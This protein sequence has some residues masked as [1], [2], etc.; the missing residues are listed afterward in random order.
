MIRESWGGSEELWAAMAEEALKERHKVIHFSYKFQPVH[1][2]MQ[3]LIS[4]GLVCYTRPSYKKVFGNPVF[5]IGHKAFFFF[6]KRI[7]RSLKKVFEQSPDIVLY[8][9]TCYSIAEEK[10]L[11][12][13][14][15]KQG[16]RFFILGHFNNDKGE[17]LSTTAKETIRQCY[18]KCK[19]IFFVAK[20]SIQTAIRDLD[21]NIPQALVIRNPVNI[22]STEIVPWPESKTVHF[23]MVGNLVIIHKGQDI[24]LNALASAQWKSRSW[25][26][27]IYGSGQDEAFLKG[28]VKSL[29]L[30]NNVTFH[31]RVTDIRLVWKEN[32]VLLMPSHMEGMPLAVVEAMICGRPVIATD[33]GGHKEWIENSVEG[34]IAETP[35]VISFADAMKEAWCKKNDWEMMGKKAHE[36]A[37]RLYDPQPGK[38]LLHLLTS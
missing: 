2:K 20:R 14:W 34:F 4:K 10:Q 25:H 33:V 26:L 11:L 37:M 16:I 13:Y 15:G 12:R 5:E 32:H 38:T 31:G 36:K 29:G 22:T 3:A 7:N 9:G 21:T 6:Q 19:Q 30:T 28:L 1:P 17:N 35:T 24:T 27:N 23:A 8:N 18:S